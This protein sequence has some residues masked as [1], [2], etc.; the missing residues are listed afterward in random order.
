MLRVSH[1]G[2]GFIL[3][4]GS[5]AGGAVADA[6]AQQLLFP[7]EGL[8]HDHSRGQDHGGG[9]IHFRGRLDGE[10]I[11]HGVDRRDLGFQNGDVQAFQLSAHAICQGHAADGGQA[12]IVEDGFCL[13]Q[14]FTQVPGAEKPQ[15]LAA[16]LCRNGGRNAA[17]P[18]ADDGNVSSFHRWFPFRID[19]V[20]P[21][22]RL[23]VAEPLPPGEGQALT[24]STNRRK[25]S[26]PSGV[27]L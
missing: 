23:G 2:H 16:D 13:F 9:F 24:A 27:R 20:P 3:I 8:A 11:P 19:W 22:I 10:V 14:L 21:R 18:G 17:G 25:A 1:Y 12:G 26:F 6:P 7:W 4:K 15:L 5:V